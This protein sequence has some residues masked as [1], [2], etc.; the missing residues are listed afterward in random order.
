MKIAKNSVVEL[1]YTLTVD[2]QVAD[3]TT[4]E[5]PLDFIFG[6]GSLLPKFEEYILD[7]EPEDTFAFVL[8]PEEGYGVHDPNAIIELPK[9][10]F[11]V[12]GKI[13]EGLLTVGNVLPMMNNQG[14]VMPGKIV[15]VKDDT[16]IMDF[17]HAMAGKE[18]HFEGK[19]LTVRE[20]TEEELRDGLHGEFKSSCGGGCSCDGGCSCGD[21]GC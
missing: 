16:V 12:D 8:S 19:I 17:N 2:G 1:I 5:R 15:E 20:A 10:I 18:L 6:I 11:E 4:E 3:S 9:N 21:C 14:G 13:Q 7:K